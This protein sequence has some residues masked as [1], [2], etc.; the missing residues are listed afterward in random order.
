MSQDLMA[1]LIA[2]GGTLI[3]SAL[4]MAWGWT[5]ERQCRRLAR[6]LR[7]SQLRELASQADIR[8]LRHDLDRWRTAYYDDERGTRKTTYLPR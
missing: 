7:E 5:K 4:P 1:A 2:A 6:L 8:A 3:G